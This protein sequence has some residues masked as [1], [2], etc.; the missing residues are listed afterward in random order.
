MLDEFVSQDL[1]GSIT[2]PDQKFKLTFEMDGPYQEMLI[3]WMGGLCGVKK[4]YLVRSLNAEGSWELAK[5]SGFMKMG[6]GFLLKKNLEKECIDCWVRN[7][8]GGSENV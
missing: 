1:S 4:K 8:D 2:E 5:Y 6:A 7:G 3:P